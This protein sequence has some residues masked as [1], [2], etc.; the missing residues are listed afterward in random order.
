VVVQASITAMRDNPALARS[1]D[2]GVVDQAGGYELVTTA[3]QGLEQREQQRRAKAVEEAA[4]SA[5]A[6]TL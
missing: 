3:E 5:D 6:P 2:V 1:L 4:K